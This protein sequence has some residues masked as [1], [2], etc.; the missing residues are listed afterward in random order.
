MITKS[1]IENQEHFSLVIFKCRL[2]LQEEIEEIIKLFDNSKGGP[3]LDLLK[4][5]SERTI[6]KL[7]VRRK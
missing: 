5:H 4:I 2:I 1:E 6:D 7:R 3:C